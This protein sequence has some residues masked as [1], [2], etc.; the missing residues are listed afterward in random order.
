LRK[1]RI[2]KQ[3]LELEKIKDLENNWLSDEKIIEDAINRKP[4]YV[5]LSDVNNLPYEKPTKELLLRKYAYLH[6][7][8]VEFHDELGH[9]VLWILTEFEKSEK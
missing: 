8:K 7:D 4:L 2:K 5:Y 6:H 3:R 9:A 1:E